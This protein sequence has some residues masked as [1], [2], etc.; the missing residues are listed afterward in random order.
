MGHQVATID[1][2]AR[3]LQTLASGMYDVLIMDVTLPD[4]SGEE[5]VAAIPAAN[6][7]PVVLMSGFRNVDQVLAKQPRVYG[8]L[9]KPFTADEFLQLLKRFPRLS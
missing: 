3:A 6:P 4:I 1:S 8:L 7:V 5:V 9:S 2:G